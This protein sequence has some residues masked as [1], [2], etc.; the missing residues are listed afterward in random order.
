MVTWPPFDAR[1]TLP[2]LTFATKKLS[3]SANEQKEDAGSSHLPVQFLV[4]VGMMLPRL[5]G[6][7]SPTP[8]VTDVG[9]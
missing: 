4:M 1:A 2:E 8:A 9:N 6:G 7:I 3:T 5:P